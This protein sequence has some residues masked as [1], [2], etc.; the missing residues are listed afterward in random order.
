MKCHELAFLG[1]QIYE[2]YADIVNFFVAF[3]NQIV[4]ETYSKT[5]INFMVFALPRLISSREE[6]DIF[7]I[8]PYLL[9]LDNL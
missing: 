6:E 8:Y 7:Y 4:L 1:V 3:T 5:V 9:D 2:E